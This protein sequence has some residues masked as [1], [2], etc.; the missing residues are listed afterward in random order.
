MESLPKTATPNPNAIARLELMTGGQAKSLIGWGGLVALEK[1]GRRLKLSDL[2]VPPELML[3]S[4]LKFDRSE[5]TKTIRDKIKKRLNETILD[6]NLRRSAQARFFKHGKIRPELLKSLSES[7]AE[8]SNDIP[9][10]RALLREGGLYDL[11]RGKV[12]ESHFNKKFHQTVATPTSLGRLSARPDMEL[13]EFARFFWQQTEEL[14]Q[15]ISKLITKLTLVQI[16]TGLF[17]YRKLR[18]D[19][20]REARF[21][22]TRYAI[23]SKLSG[24]EVT[25]KEL[26]HM[27]GTRIFVDAFWEYVFEKLDRYA[28]SKSKDFAQVA[29]FKRGDFADFTHLLYLPYV[30]VFGCDGEMK[31]RINRAGWSTEKVVTNDFA[32]ESLLKSKIA[33]KD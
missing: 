11:L 25:S 17:D 19:L 24:H 16:D 20:R 13:S 22:E 9:E 21:E 2:V 7:E 26:E 29:E 23:V 30:D 12:S 33:I 31:A 32:L 14:G 28:N 3:P 15:I 8:D 10:L 27:P 6:P 4:K 1:E 18:S 5:M